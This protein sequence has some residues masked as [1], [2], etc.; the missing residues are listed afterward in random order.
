M[1]DK[2]CRA[3]NFLFHTRNALFPIII[4]ALLF[5]WPPV[6]VGQYSSDFLL[7]FGLLL[8]FIG[9][10]IRILTIGLAYVIRGGRNRR[11]Y[12]ENLV[13]GGVFAHSR[14]PMYVGNILLGIGFLSVSGNIT[15]LIVGSFLILVTYRLIVHS[16]E[17]FLRE[18]FKEDYEAYCASVPRWLPR[19]HGLQE[20]IKD[21]EYKFDWPGVVVKEYSTVFMYL[22]IPMIVIAWKLHLANL[23]NEYKFII[24]SLTVILICVYAGFRF[25]KKAERLI[26]L[27]DP[28]Y[29]SKL[30]H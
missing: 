8:I 19:I 1:S 14:N 9:Q 23:F 7:Y 26:S 24:L 25:I 6:A 20:M 18:Q 29:K 13:T 12:A 15:G 30:N 28:R 3:G 4:I 27:R 10:A 22:F 17:C 16:E 21:Y 11:I 5:L 2:F